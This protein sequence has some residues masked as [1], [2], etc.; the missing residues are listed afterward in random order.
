MHYSCTV[1]KCTRG[2]AESARCKQVKHLTTMTRHVE[3]TAAITNSSLLT[4]HNSIVDVDEQ[5]RKLLFTHLDV[6]FSGCIDSSHGLALSGDFALQP[7]CLLLQLQEPAPLQTNLHT[8][9]CWHTTGHPLQNVYGCCS[10]GR[11]GARGLGEERGHYCLCPYDAFALQPAC[12]PS[13]SSNV[14]RSDPIC[15]SSPIGKLLEIHNRHGGNIAWVRSSSS[16]GQ[17]GLQR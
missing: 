4:T 8:I 13:S 3:S 11:Q 2:F 15:T 14:L 7:A 9:N 12:L 5:V 1:A 17:G 16:K 6:G 10:D